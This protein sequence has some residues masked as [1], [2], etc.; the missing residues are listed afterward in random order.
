MSNRN[1]YYPAFLNL[2]GKKC[3]VIGGGKVAARKIKSLMD[4]GAMITVISPRFHPDIAR[5]AEAGFLQWLQRSCK[6][7]D[8]EDAFMVIS[9]TS[10]KR[11]NQR[12][13]DEAERRGVLVNVV[14]DP[15]RSDFIVPAL[16]R[17]G[18]LTIA[19]STSG[20]SPALAKKI[21]TRLEKDFGEEYASLIAVIEEV[22]STL[23]RKGVRAS[24]E[25]WQKA[26]DVD[27]LAELVRT[28]QAN[29]AKAALLKALNR[30]H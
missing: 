18:R 28:G 3:L 19:I 11:V 25:A 29:K 2:Q 9:A 6:E 10:N 22:R 17:R 30:N 26:L 7:G 1:R 20:M 13:A 16:V 8:L 24:S 21:R 4:C 27:S 12:I 14:D 15:K 23:K 5:L